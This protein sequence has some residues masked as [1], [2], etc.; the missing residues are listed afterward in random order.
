MLKRD[1]KIKPYAMYDSDYML[2]GVEL[3]SGGENDPI[4]DA[5]VYAKDNLAFDAEGNKL[6]FSLQ[7]CISAQDIDRDVE[8]LEDKPRAYRRWDQ[9]VCVTII[10][11]RNMYDYM[12]FENSDSSWGEII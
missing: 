3:Y 2:S 5:T 4:V 6:P 12:F 7:V 9:K 1:N 11:W 10:V 8:L